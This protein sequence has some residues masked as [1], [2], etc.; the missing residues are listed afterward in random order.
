MFS[1]DVACGDVALFHDHDAPSSSIS[2]SSGEV[3]VNVLDILLVDSVLI[4]ISPSLV[5]AV[6]PFDAIYMLSPMEQDAD[7]GVRPLKH[8][9]L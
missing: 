6:T 5:A 4:L 7:V 8:F 9:R 1:S 2:V 3:I